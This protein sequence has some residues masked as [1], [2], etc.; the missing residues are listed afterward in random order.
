MPIFI[1]V[2]LYYN[3]MLLAMLAGSSWPTLRTLNLFSQF[4]LC[5]FFSNKVY[6]FY[7]P[8]HKNQESYTINR[9][10]IPQGKLSFYKWSG[11]ETESTQ[12]SAY[13]GS[14]KE[15]QTRKLLHQSPKETRETAYWFRDILQSEL[16][17]VYRQNS[18]SQ[19][20]YLTSTCL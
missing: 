20:Q 14:P 9:H 5:N 8:A 6:N 17:D 7:A 16:N 18:F 10:I 1:Y 4:C 13:P 19:N 15:T 3:L 11:I 12:M 2:N